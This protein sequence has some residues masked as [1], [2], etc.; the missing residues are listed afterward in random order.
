LATSRKRSRI[1]TELPVEVRKSVNRLLVEGATYEE[2]SAYLIEQGYDISRSSV[3]RYGKDFFDMLSR[4]RVDE[5]KADALIEGDDTMALEHAASKLLIQQVV[6]GIASCKINVADIPRIMSDVAK[7]QSSS[8]QREK[9]RHEIRERA[10]KVADTVQTKLTK[11]GVS[12]E[13]ADMIRRDVLG[14]AK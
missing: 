5:A 6:N 4:L 12:K 2:V 14:I 13:L 11:A 1:E 7:L 8:I 10:A 3:G 9:Y